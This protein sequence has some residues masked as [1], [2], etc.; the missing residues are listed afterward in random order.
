MPSTIWRSVSSFCTAPFSAIPVPADL[1]LIRGMPVL[2]AGFSVEIDQ[3]PESAR[4]AADGGPINGSPSAPAR[5]NDFGVPPTPSQIGR[6]FCIG[7]GVDPRRRR[8]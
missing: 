2:P 8:E 3:R 6:D 4:L 1:K 7:R 5:A